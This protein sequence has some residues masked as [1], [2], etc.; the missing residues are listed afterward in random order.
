MARGD[1]IY[2]QCFAGGIP[3]QHH[4]IDVGDDQIIHLA[5][6]DGRRIVLSDTGDRF[7][8]RSDSRAE[9]CRGAVPVVV[10]HS[11][12][13]DADAVVEAAQSLLG[14]RGYN[15][16]EG[17]C[18]HFAR[19]C[20]CGRAESHQIELGQATLSAL[21]SMTTKAVW[22]VSS[23]VSAGWVVRGAMRV[24]PASM[25]A[26]GVEL[27]ALAIG[28]RRGMNSDSAR[29]VAR[30]SGRVAAVGVGAALGG[31][32]GAALSLAAHSSS[33]AIADSLCQFL[34]RSLSVKAKVEKN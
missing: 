22:A 8:V 32:A 7:S 2:V 26:D 18:E 33:T 17:N 25:M 11:Q 28:C 10:V 31:P 14:T 6:A 9:F 19:L 34:R 4:G 13:R 27:A 20:A 23:R 3:Y 24:H 1:H 5:P 16:L 15:L 30:L 12:G 29:R 21:A